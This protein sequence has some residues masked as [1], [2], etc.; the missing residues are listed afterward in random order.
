[1]KLST[2]LRMYA[3]E[4]KK[5]KQLFF[6]LDRNRR[7][8]TLRAQIEES[9]K[10]IKRINTEIKKNELLGHK[11]KVIRLKIIRRLIYLTAY[12]E[13]KI[14][15]LMV[16]IGRKIRD[17]NNNLIFVKKKREQLMNEYKREVARARTELYKIKEEILYKDAIEREFNMRDRSQRRAL[18]DL[19]FEL[20]RCDG[21]ID[22][23]EELIADLN[24]LETKRIKKYLNDLSA[25]A[26]KLENLADR[27]DEIKE[28]IRQGVKV[29]I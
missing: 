29:S 24:A 17:L 4:T 25:L 18:D 10:A 19:S 28:S 3:K 12:V 27:I 1:M 26:D 8:L 21:K 16:D 15:L 6:K 2:L 11:I 5:S 20:S 23:Y 9:N 22:Y 13:L 7:L 14:I